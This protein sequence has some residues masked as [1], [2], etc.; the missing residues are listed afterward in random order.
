LSRG[1]ACTGQQEFEV[2]DTLD[3]RFNRVGKGLRQ[4]LWELVCPNQQRRFIAAKILAGMQN[5]APKRMLLEPGFDYSAYIALFNAEVRRIASE[6]EFD[7]VTYINLL[8][9]LMQSAQKERMNLF[10][11]ETQATD[12]KLDRVVRRITEELEATSDTRRRAVL[13]LRL[14]RALCADF[15]NETPGS[16]LQ[17]RLG[18]VQ[19]AAAQVFEALGPLVFDAPERVRA[20]LGDSDSEWVLVRVMEA[21][22]KAAAPLF[23]NLLAV[24]DSAV[25]AHMFHLPRALAAVA[26]HD[27][28]RIRMLVLRLESPMPGV[29]CGAAQTIGF[30]GQPA[31]E[32]APGLSGT[33]LRMAAAE[34]P[35]RHAAIVALGPV[36]RGTTAA[37]DLLVKLCEE[38]DEW[39]RGPAITALG[40]IACDPERIIPCL[41]RAL[42]DFEDP[43]PDYH[44]YSSHMRA[45]AA[46]AAFGAAALP[47]LP[48]L[49]KRIRRE[50]GELDRGVLDAIAAIGPT[51]R[52]ALPALEAIADQYEC[53]LEDT[54]DPLARAITA[55]KRQSVQMGA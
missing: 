22:G 14:E 34:H 21:Q 47:A 55:L 30:I 52:E 41:C 12:A 26:A 33:L 45:T 19:I 2:A 43:D 8:A 27:P 35:A 36:T 54:W 53:D 37:V 48:G 51:A 24:L 31:R 32:A 1:P 28:D 38:G 20:M 16:R 25:E 9:D 23:P 18:D 13:Q 17:A 42:E 40:E 44:D 7:H 4:W 11:S 5:Y 3:R 6:P 10:R 49:L 29:S 39:L 50:E 46:L 15:C